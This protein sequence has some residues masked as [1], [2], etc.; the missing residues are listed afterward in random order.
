MY[1]MKSAFV[2]SC[3]VLVAACHSS[4]PAP[5][6]PT[7]S[8]PTSPAPVASAPVQPDAKMRIHLINVGQGAATLVEFSCGAV[9][10]DTGGEE[11][12]GF[13][14]TEHLVAYLDGFFQHRPDLDNTLAELVITDPH[15]DQDRGAEAVWTKFHV[16][17]VVTDGLTVSSGGKEQAKLIDEADAAHVPEDK[18]SEHGMARDGLHDAVVDPLV[19]DDG[20]PDIRALWGNVDESDVQWSDKALKNYNNDS[21]VLK[22]TLGKSSFIVTGDLEEHGIAA[23]LER[24][25][26]TNDL[27]ADVYEVGHHASH[28]STTW[29]LLRAITPKIALISMGSPERH[30]TDSAWAFGHPRAVVI[31]LLEHALAGEKRAAITVPVATGAKAFK[32]HEVSAPI[33][34]TGWDGNVVVTMY[35]D[36]RY[37]VA[38]KQ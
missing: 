10:V 24:Y 31:D 11:N 12:P 20:D 13:H 30:L 22:F 3:L 29:A 38:T 5:T 23:M 27:D 36:G 1:D 16:Q 6:T 2:T 21:V 28:S 35:G 19:C 25:A 8:A 7:P 34:A 17:N 33:Y 26:G 9:L 15:I 37:E 14:S 18:V 4:S 32:Q